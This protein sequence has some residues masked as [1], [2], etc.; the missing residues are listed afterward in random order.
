MR[1]DRY[2][3]VARKLVTRFRVL[4]AP[5]DITGLILFN[6]QTM[7]TFFEANLFGGNLDSAG[8]RA[9]NL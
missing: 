2:Q 7:L 8:R 4:T 9:V 3:F 6:V 5:F 1:F